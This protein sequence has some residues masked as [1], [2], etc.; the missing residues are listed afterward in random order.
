MHSSWSQADRWV[1]T[2]STRAAPGDGCWKCCM[3]A[4][5]SA[6]WRCSPTSREPPASRPRCDCEVLRLERGAFLDLVRQQPSVALA[7]AATISRRMAAMLH[8]RNEFEPTSWPPHRCRPAR[9]RRTPLPPS[10][11]ALA[12]GAHRPRRRSGHRHIGGRLAAAAA[13]RNVAGRMARAGGVAGR[14]AGARARRAARRGAGAAARRRLGGAGRGARGRRAVRF[15]QPQLGAG[16]CGADHRLSHRGVRRA[17][18]ACAGD[19][20]PHPRRLRRR[21]D[22]AFARRPVDRPGGAQCHQPRHHHRTDDA[23]AGRGAGLSAEIEGGRRH[24]HGGADRIRPDGRGVS[25]ELDHRR[26]GG[27]GAA[28]RGAARPELDHLGALRRARQHHPVRRAAR[29]PALALSAAR[30]R[31]GGTPAI[32]RPCSRCNGRCSV[33][34]RATRRSRSPSASACWSASSRSPCTGSI[35]PGWRF[36]PPPCWLRPGSSPSIRCAR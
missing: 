10:T 9:R 17:L 8:P 14:V 3:R 4:S 27:G 28:G 32:A 21:G 29:V 1:S 7:I 11:P 33:R 6:R 31:T 22:G 12:A 23:G 15:R 18:S 25:D 26:A 36:W 20:H 13:V 16:G 34:C 5:R 24:R 35:P 2:R 30:R 19:H